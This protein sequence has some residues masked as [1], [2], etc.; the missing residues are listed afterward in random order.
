M[1]A[2]ALA[3]ILTPATAAAATATGTT[4]TSQFPS[5]VPFQPPSTTGIAPLNSGI[6]SVP[7]PPNVSPF[8]IVPTPPSP[9]NPFGALPGRR[10]AI[11][12]TCNGSNADP[13]ECCDAA[14]QGIVCNGVA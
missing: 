6:A 7:V 10:V 11:S 4:P 8:S 12:A 1:G 2:G 3:P 13:D 9:S 14:L 5:P